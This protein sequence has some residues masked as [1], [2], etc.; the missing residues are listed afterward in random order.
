MTSKSNTLN[1]TIIPVSLRSTTVT[2]PCKPFLELS[3]A[4]IA[5]NANLALKIWEGLP[6][7]SDEEENARIRSSILLK[8]A[9]DYPSDDLKYLHSTCDP[10]T[11]VFSKD[12]S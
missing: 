10:K 4:R 3:A 5:R 8:I 6:H 1:G 12:A 11:C 7:S 9:A 2:Y